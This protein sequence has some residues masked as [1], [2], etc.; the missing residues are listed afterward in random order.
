MR[1]DRCHD[2]HE[3]GTRGAIIIDLG[4][5]ISLFLVLS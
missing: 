5:V 2:R 3:E 4:S 1:G